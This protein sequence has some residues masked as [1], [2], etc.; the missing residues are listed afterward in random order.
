MS[1]ERLEL[2]L[3][4]ELNS[5]IPNLKDPRIPLVVTVERVNLSKDGK[6]AKVLVSTLNE[7]D[8]AD[9]LAALDRSKGYLQGQLAQSMQKRFTPRLSFFGN[10][11]DVLT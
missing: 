6:T 5:L 9:L 8:M 1:N 11:L 7:E 4:R 2:S 3:A 10:L